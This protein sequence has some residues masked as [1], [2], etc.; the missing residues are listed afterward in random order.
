MDGPIGG[1]GNGLRTLEWIA[2]RFV[3]GAD[4]QGTPT[5]SAGRRA[6]IIECPQR[7]LTVMRHERDRFPAASV[8]KIAIAGAAW[9]AL[10]A[11]A[12][13]PHARWA[14][15]DLDATR[16]CSILASFDP[17]RRLSLRDLIGLMLVISDNPATT[18]VLETIG[19]Q[20]VRRWLDAHGLHDTRLEAGFRDADLDQRARTNVTT[21]HDCW[22][23]LRV[24]RDTPRYA[25]L[26][27][28]LRNNVRNDRMPRQL[29]D[30]VAVAHKTGTL[31]GVRHDVGVMMGAGPEVFLVMLTEEQADPDA[32]AMDMARA[33]RGIHRV[34]S[35]ERDPGA[36][37]DA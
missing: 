16:Y 28:M 34:L 14:V 35:G 31:A 15:G 21:A 33:A 27:A 1:P 9:D 6:L 30:D 2:D 3:T 25:P 5:P 10:D 8:I 37:A 13:D 19:L 36:T 32:T 23:M 17:Q 7:G 22:R 4:P 12:S 29:P 18:Q 11:G 24:V 20:P 26:M